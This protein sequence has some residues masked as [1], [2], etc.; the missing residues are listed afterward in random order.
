MVDGVIRTDYIVAVVAPFA[1]FN[2]L[3]VFWLIC[4]LSN[5]LLPHQ[6]A[7]VLLILLNVCSILIEIVLLGRLGRVITGEDFGPERRLVALMRD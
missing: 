1:D 3:V 6:P 7:L 5:L 2:A 4:N